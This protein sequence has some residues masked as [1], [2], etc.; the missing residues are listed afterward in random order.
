MEINKLILN[1]SDNKNIKRRKSLNYIA[2]IKFL[3][4]IKI[5]KWHIYKWKKRE[6]EYG[7]RM[8]EILFISS[9]FLVGYN[10]YQRNMP[11]DYDMSFKYSYKH[12]RNFYPLE[13]INLIYGIIIKPHKKFNLTELEIIISNLLIIKSWCTNIELAQYFTGISWFLSNLLFCYFLVP[14]LLKGIKL[15]KNSLIIFLAVCFIR[16]LIEEI[17][18]NG[19]KN[20]FHA[21]FHRGPFIRLLEFYMGMLLIP[22]FFYIKVLLDKNKNKYCIKFM[23]SI[24]QFLCAII[25]YIIML[26][27]NKKLLRCY[28]VLIFSIIIFIIGFD[29]GLFSHLFATKLFIRLMSCQMEM[30]LLQKTINNIILSLAKEIKIQ[31]I[32]NEEMKFLIKLLI[33]FAIG[34][35]YKLFLKEKLAYLM[36]I[37]ASF[38]TISLK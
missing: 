37:M 22:S 38:F 35:L 19:A 24:I 10:Y 4:M 16:I 34:F 14:L 25:L 3:A 26:K 6:I 11:C 27:Y 29:Y 21:D 31:L 30:Y 32:L 5:I 33:I 13:C 28:F 23:F 15:I 7:Q 12:L 1:I 36:D 20:I 2:F 18:Y 9:G 17:I 8:C